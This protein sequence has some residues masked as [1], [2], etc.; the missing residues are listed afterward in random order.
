MLCGGRGS[1]L[2]C[3]RKPVGGTLWDMEEG[4]R[5]EQEVKWPAGKEDL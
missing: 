2:H 5:K 1:Q 3:C 4:P